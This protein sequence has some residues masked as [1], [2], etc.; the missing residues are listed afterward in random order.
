MNSVIMIG[1]LARDP[2]LR[3]VA[4]SGKAVAN[5]SIAVDRPFS[6]EKQADFFR[7]VVWGK[8]AENCANYLAKGRKVAVK[9]YL[10]S[11]SYE[12]ANGE[13]KYV[14]EIVAD[15]VEFLEWGDRN[16]QGSARPQQNTQSFSNGF[17]S[18]GFQAIE[19]DDDIP[20]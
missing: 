11:R 13:K 19:D 5:F 10:T 20:F 16:E 17:D 7:V 6:K 9:G 18:D 15:N 4:G 1:R 2:E 14:T 8:P 12:A 3:F